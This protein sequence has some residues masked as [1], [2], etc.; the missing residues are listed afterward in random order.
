[1]NVKY[2][3]YSL[4]VTAELCKAKGVDEDVFDVENIFPYGMTISDMMG[5]VCSSP[6][7]PTFPQVTC[8]VGL[9]LRAGA[10]APADEYTPWN[11]YIHR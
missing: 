6:N 7:C 5:F 1:M 10:I 8:D 2:R 9:P 3:D 11:T 4:L